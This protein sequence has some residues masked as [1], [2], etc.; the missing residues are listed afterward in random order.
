MSTI[1]RLVGIVWA[2]AEERFLGSLRPNP[3]KESHF[4]PDVVT[5]NLSVLQYQSLNRSHRIFRPPQKTAERQEH[6]VSVPSSNLF[7]NLIQVKAPS[8]GKR[9]RAFLSTKTLE[10]IWVGRYDDVA[11]KFLH[12]GY[13]AYRLLHKTIH[14]LSFKLFFKSLHRLVLYEI[15]FI[16]LKAG[17]PPI[18][19]RKQLTSCS[20]TPSGALLPS[21]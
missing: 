4:F 17:H 14:N 13:L 2:R 3:Y 10:K 21:Y 20:S 8:R 5:A 15:T 16:F 11:C 7:S 1:H 6:P 9:K 12:G 19:S 18:A